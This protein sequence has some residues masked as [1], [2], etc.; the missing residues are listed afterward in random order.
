MQGAWNRLELALLTNG[1]VQRL[2]A[3]SR[4]GLQRAALAVPPRAWSATRLGLLHSMRQTA[5]GWPAAELLEQPCGLAEQQRA[6]TALRVLRL[7]SLWYLS[8][9]VEPARVDGW[10][11]PQIFN[12]KMEC[13]CISHTD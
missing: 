9:L 1:E 11:S 13:P 3:R 7:A 10:N 5:A 2:Q 8:S 12:A 4:G 6:P